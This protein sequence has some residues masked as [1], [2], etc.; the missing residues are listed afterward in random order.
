M[1]STNSSFAEVVESSL[2]QFTAQTWQ[3]DKAPSFGMLVTAHDENQHLF[4]IVYAIKTGSS[5]PSRAPFAYQ[6]TPAELKQDQPHIFVFLK[7]TFSC[8]VVGSLENGVVSYTLAVKPVQIH[9]F[10]QPASTECSHLFFSST[11][12]LHLLFGVHQGTTHTD[13]LLLALI[14]HQSLASDQA[15][16]AIMKTYVSLTGSDYRRIRLFARRVNQIR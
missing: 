4:G 13:E 15:L 14:K 16:E 9:T 12:Y 6:K 8:L 10:V 11:A 7:T 2:E 1:N 5:D 3:W